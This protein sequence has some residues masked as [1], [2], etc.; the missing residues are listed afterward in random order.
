MTYFFGIH[1]SHATYEEFENTLKRKF[2]SIEYMRGYLDGYTFGVNYKLFT[3]KEFMA[4][5]KK[6]Y[7]VSE[8]HW[9][10]LDI[11]LPDEDN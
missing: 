2:P 1:A 10:D 8:Y 7:D 6:R 4:F 9:F 5:V 3:T 11:V